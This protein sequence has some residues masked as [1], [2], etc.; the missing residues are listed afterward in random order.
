MVDSD[1]SDD[2]DDKIDDVA[3]MPAPP[4]PKKMK[5][6]QKESPSA[7]ATKLYEVQVVL[8]GLQENLKMN[9]KKF[10]DAL[11]SCQNRSGRQIRP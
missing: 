9:P 2:K 4:A 8:D 11:K 10:L 7:A 6:T 5:E 1:E 3:A